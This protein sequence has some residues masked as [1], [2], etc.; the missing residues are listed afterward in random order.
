MIV[1]LNTRDSAWTGEFREGL[2]AI[3]ETGARGARATRGVGHSRPG[4]RP[5]DRNVEYALAHGGQIDRQGRL[6]VEVGNAREVVHESQYDLHQK[7]GFVQG[8]SLVLS[9][10][11]RNPFEFERVL[12]LLQRPPVLFGDVQQLR[13]NKP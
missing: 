4:E 5:S 9:T 6:F 3:K 1:S 7:F 12:S 10:E 2:G 11:E 13:D 8:K